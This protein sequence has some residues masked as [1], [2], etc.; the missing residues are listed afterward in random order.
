VNRQTLVVT[1]G[2][3]V[4]VALAGALMYTSPGGDAESPKA[5]AAAGKSK[6]TKPTKATK[7]A[8]ST[9]KVPA[10]KL[11]HRLEIPADRPA[12]PEGA[13]HVV[14]VITSTM[15]KDLLSVY[16]GQSGTTPFLDEKAKEGVLATD[17]LANAVWPKPS[18]VALLTGMYPHAV[19]MVETRPQRDSLR[20]APEGVLLSERFAEA[21]WTTVG[22]T[23]SHYMNGRFGMRQGFD[24]FRE[25]QPFG[26]PLEARLPAKAAVDAVV[27]GVE[28]QRKKAADRPVY[29]QVAFIDSHK[30]FKVPPEEFKAFEG[31]HEIA[32]YLATLLR[33]DQAVARL[34]AELAKQGI[35]ADNTVFVVVGDH[36]EGLDMPVHHRKQHGRSL[37]ASSVEIPWVMWG[38]G[39]A[40]GT[41]VDGLVSQIDLAPTL[42]GLS[43]LPATGLDGMD[44]SALMKKGGTSPRTLHYADTFYEKV[45][46]SSVWTS[47]MQ[48]QKDFGTVQTEPD[49]TFVDG[50]YDRK[51]D[52]DFTKPIPDEALMSKLT[53]EHDAH[54]AAAVASAKAPTKNP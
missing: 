53:A 4:L 41:K 43:G 32:P 42:L 9:E 31:D 49:P 33:Q 38:K 24:W 17:A 48:C 19:G 45:H 25:S 29:V 13:T 6:A 1:V 26:Y 27:R 8:A 20:L 23:A 44:L 50:C 3:V 52:K 14:V 54:L 5:S 46:R 36:G 28:T 12:A 37:Y 22:A 35:T 10:S 7:A 30:P 16:G 34:V 15:R 39:I 51:A 21:G 47:T 2:T 11:I 18:Q 40:P